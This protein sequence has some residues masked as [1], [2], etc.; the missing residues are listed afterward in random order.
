MNRFWVVPLFFALF[1]IGPFLV[2]G[3]LLTALL[4]PQGTL[5][6]LQ[7]YKSIGWIIGIGLL[8]AD[9]FLP[10]PA[11][12][13]IAALGILYGPLIATLIGVVGSLLAAGIGYGIGHYLGRP[14]AQKFVGDSIVTGER[15]FAQ[16]GGWI[17]A[18]SRWMPVLP[19]VVSCVAGV[20]R[21]PLVPFLGAVFCGSLPLCAT[22]AL[23]GDL[24]AD[25][26]AWTLAISALAP[27]ALWYAAERTGL[28]RKFGVD[29]LLEPKG[30]QHTEDHKL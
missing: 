27:F 1:V 6:V 25:K 20:S 16:Y 26:P 18:A 10:I 13:V 21:M 5:D 15:V 23:L 12:A 19:E 29:Q 9:L 30:P 2:W 3:D 14:A 28:T 22:F 24:G 4:S 7:G 17:V 11:T 8:I